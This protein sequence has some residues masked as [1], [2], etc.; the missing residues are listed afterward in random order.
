MY[1]AEAGEDM[2]DVC[3]ALY[4]MPDEILAQNPNLAFPL[5]EGEQVI[6]FRGLK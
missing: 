2:L 4:A 1:I 5:A 3:K 6:Y